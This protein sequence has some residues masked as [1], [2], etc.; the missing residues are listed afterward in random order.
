MEEP[1]ANFE[2]RLDLTQL[3]AKYEKMV[4]EISKKLIGQNRLI[5]MIMTAILSDGHVLI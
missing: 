5:E 4:K 2:S 1:E 3:T